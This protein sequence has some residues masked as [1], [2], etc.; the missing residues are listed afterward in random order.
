M[1]TAFA[2]DDKGFRCDM[3]SGTSVVAGLYFPSFVLFTSFVMLNLVIAVVID[4]FIESAQSEGLLK[5][6]SSGVGG[7][8]RRVV[9]MWEYGRANRVQDMH[10]ACLLPS[11]RMLQTG[12][13]DPTVGASTIQIPV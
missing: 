6:R 9:V 11:D 10:R 3:V 13:W 4:N 7:S 12:S 8:E 5:V 1:A 2:C